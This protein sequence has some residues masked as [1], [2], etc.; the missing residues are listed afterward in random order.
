MIKLKKL[1]KESKYAWD[2]KFGDPLPT[3]KDI[4]E[5]HQNKP[6]E[7]IKEAKLPQLKVP[8]DVSYYNRDWGEVFDKWGDRFVVEFGP[9]ESDIYDWNDRR[10]Y[11]KVV[12]EFNA[13]MGHVA[14]VLNKAAQGLQDPY[15][16]WNKI[17]EKHR[18]KDRS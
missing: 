5:T 6:K 3:F 15:K 4:A 2:R 13:E 1:L 9:R 12:K 18:K 17:L 11:D 14:A 7:V 16:K 8:S 10:N